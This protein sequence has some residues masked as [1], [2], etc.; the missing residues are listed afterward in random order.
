[1]WIYILNVTIQLGLCSV[2]NAHIRYSVIHMK[3]SQERAF[4]FSKTIKEWNC[5]EIMNQQWCNIFKRCE[6]AGFKQKQLGCNINVAL[7]C[8]DFRLKCYF[9]TLTFLS[10]LKWFGGR[11]YKS[12]LSGLQLRLENLGQFHVLAKL[13][14]YQWVRGI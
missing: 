12:S 11:V 1:M 8:Q 2:I 5:I 10:D 6:C 7:S 9:F 3:I 14:R 13:H 4:L